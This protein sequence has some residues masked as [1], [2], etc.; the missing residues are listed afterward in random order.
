[1]RENR[2]PPCASRSRPSRSRAA[3]YIESPEVDRALIAGR[4]DAHAVKPI[5]S[6]SLL[7]IV[8]R[9]IAKRLEA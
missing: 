7:D 5:D 8:N 6:R 4:L 3:A 1:L 9:A 2:P